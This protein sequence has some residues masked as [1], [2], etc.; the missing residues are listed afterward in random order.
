MFA[1]LPGVAAPRLSFLECLTV[2][3]V[4]ILDGVFI[5]AE[6]WNLYEIDR[7]EGKRAVVGAWLPSLGPRM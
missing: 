7:F 1:I 4:A 3:I 5:A 2:W 6:W